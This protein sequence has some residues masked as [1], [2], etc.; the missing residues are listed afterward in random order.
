MVARLVHHGLAALRS[1]LI[2]GGASGPAEPFNFEAFL[3]A[4]K[5]LPNDDNRA[6]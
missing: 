3:A 6:H 5:H 2:E 4:H 1:A